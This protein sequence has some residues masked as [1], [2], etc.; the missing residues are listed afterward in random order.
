MNRYLPEW[1]LEIFEQGF[2][3]KQ[4]KDVY[5]RNLVLK[6]ISGC[7]GKSTIARLLSF[8]L[9]FSNHVC[10]SSFPTQK[11]RQSII[12]FLAK[13][14][15]QVVIFDLVRATF[16]RLDPESIKQKV[17]DEVSEEIRILDDSEKDTKFFEKFVNQKEYVS[18]VSE[19]KRKLSNSLRRRLAKKC[20]L[21][22]NRR[23]IERKKMGTF[24]EACTQGFSIEERF[25]IKV[26]LSETPIRIL[27]VNNDEYMKHISPDYKENAYVLVIDKNKCIPNKKN[28]KYY[29]LL[30]GFVRNEIFGHVFDGVSDA[31]ITLSDLGVSSDLIERSPEPLTMSFGPEDKELND[32]IIGEMK[33]G[34]LVGEM[35]VKLIDNK[36]F[37]VIDKLNLKYNNY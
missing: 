8:A 13:F 23:F 27:I 19:H 32:E 35:S 9:G 24:M 1:I 26:T 15:R 22:S 25:F 21:A 29:H 37:F 3:I 2:G 30:N 28:L 31:I 7:T 12:Y 36:L 33:S 14:K 6:C 11:R 34:A 18:Q 10:L 4:A 20:R 17:R 5:R 16:G